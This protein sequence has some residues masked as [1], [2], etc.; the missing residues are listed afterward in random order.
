MADTKK[1]PYEGGSGRPN[2]IRASTNT[3]ALWD[4]RYRA[5]ELRVAGTPYRAIAKKV[6]V[7]LSVVNEDI[8]AALAEKEGGN[9]ARLRALEEERLD[10]AIAAA[11]EVLNKNKGTELALKAVDRIVRAVTT[12]SNLLGLNAPVELN[13]RTTEKTQ[14]DLELEELLREADARNQVTRE[15]LIAQATG[16]SSPA[17]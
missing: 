3:Q 5:L 2:G 10:T 14:A 1:P 8:K 17:T 15:Q 11:Y 13:I 7:T 9:I 6:G 16:D 12:R 4:R